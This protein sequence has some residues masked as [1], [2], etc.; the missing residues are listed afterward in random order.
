MSTG[1]IWQTIWILACGVL[2]AWLA[3]YLTLDREVIA[4]AL[5]GTLGFIV[6]MG[7]GGAVFVSPGEFFAG[8]VR[9]LGRL[10]F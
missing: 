10:E 7:L 4:T 2:G 9:L 5:F 6:G 1:Q 3:V 8:I